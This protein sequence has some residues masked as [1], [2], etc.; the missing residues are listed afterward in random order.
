MSG[1]FARWGAMAKVGVRM[2]FHDR[3]KLAGTLFGVVF[4]TLLA[5]QQL[6]VL[7]GLLSK[8]LMFV[9]HAG[10][11]LWVLP[12]GAQ[13]FQPGKPISLSALTATEVVPGVAWAEPL[14]YAGGTLSLPGGGSEPVSV[15]GTRAPRYKGGP[16]NL[17]AG[18]AEAL[19]RPDAMIFEDSEREKLG[20]LN[21][22]SVRELNG[23]RVVA[24]GFT[25]G[26][27]PFGPS[28]SFAGYDLARELARFDADRTSYVLAGVAPGADPAAVKRAVQA[29]NPDLL[30]LTR[31]EFKA[32][33]VTYI[34]AS[35]GIGAS[36]GASTGFG[37]LVGLVIVSLSMFSA[38]VDNVREFGTLKAMGAT[39][40]DLAALLLTQSVVY[41]LV[42]TLIGLGVVSHVADAIRSPKLALVLPW[43]LYAGTFGVMLLLCSLAS[44]LALVRLRRVEPAMVFR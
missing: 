10:A 15:V 37:L 25:W 7:L 27:L 24:A 41:A 12:A 38:V 18:S 35:T 31:A 1:P 23:R 26:L 2:M 22:G 42:G 39:T 16:W 40:G 30:V 43:Q 8:N 13:T 36:F 11:D 20:G 9:D 21:L 29:R 33:I 19:A 6:G 17:V 3:L 4:A 5:D 34:F 14:I 28:Y 32:K 44:S